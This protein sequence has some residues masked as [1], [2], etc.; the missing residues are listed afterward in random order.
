MCACVDVPKGVG[1]RVLDVEAE[2][3][4]SYKYSH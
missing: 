4:G 1:A 3:K 2:T